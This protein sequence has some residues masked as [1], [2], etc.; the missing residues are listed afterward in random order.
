MP[1]RA[2]VCVW[3]VVV[4]AAVVAAGCDGAG[5]VCVCDTGGGCQLGCGCDSECSATCGCNLTAGCDP[6]C[7]CD[8]DCSLH[9]SCNPASNACWDACSA[10]AETTAYC[11]STCAIRPARYASRYP[12]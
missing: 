10:E 9:A 3:T 11:A 5:G 2:I 8:L 12:D 6:A 1:N 4:L 7:T